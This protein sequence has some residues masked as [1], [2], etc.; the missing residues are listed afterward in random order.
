MKG[1]LFAV[2]IVLAAWSLDA[3]QQQAN[4]Q[5]ACS[6]AYAH[7]RDVSLDT[8]LPLLS[9]DLSEET[10][11]IN[12]E[13]D[14]VWQALE[15]KTTPGLA[16]IASSLGQWFTSLDA[17]FRA[18]SDVLG[19]ATPTTIEACDTLFSVYEQRLAATEREQ[20]SIETIID[21]FNNDPAQSDLRGFYLT[22]AANARKVIDAHTEFEPV[23]GNYYRCRLGMAYI[24]NW[25][26]GA[27]RVGSNPALGFNDNE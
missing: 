3:T 1:F 5:R 12:G 9:I 8:L 25:T 22:V 15:Q 14:D 20:D 26:G 6:G 11:Y 2:I 17:E 10:S 21:G 18:G 27:W 19:C 23:S 4:A 13:I 7:W 24:D 16:E